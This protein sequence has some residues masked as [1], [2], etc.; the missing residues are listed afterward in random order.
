M[1]HQHHQFALIKTNG[2]A[3][4]IATDDISYA[5]PFDTA[6]DVHPVF[7]GAEQQT[8]VRVHFKAK[9][10][11]HLDLHGITPTSLASALN[12]DPF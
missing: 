1:T 5:V 3:V 7:A 12:G 8:G 4:I 10:S 6:N 9:G 2:G 11:T